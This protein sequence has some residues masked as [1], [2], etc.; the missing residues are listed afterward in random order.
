MNPTVVRFYTV[1][2]MGIA[3]Q[4]ISL[5]V[6]ADGLR[7]HPAVATFGAVQI[8]IAH[9]FVWHE[10]WTWAHRDVGYSAWQRYCR[11]VLSTGLISVVAN[12][13]VTGALVRFSAMPLTI[14]NLLAIATASVA[15]Y[16]ASDR[17]VFKY[18][19]HAP[20]RRPSVKFV[21]AGSV[22]EPDSER[23][24]AEFPAGNCPEHAK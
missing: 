15:N 16:L 17:F 10:R 5:I 23:S 2:L 19:G 13:L 7:L 1:G 4:L 20:V 12:L 24:N 21:R 14:A 3:V 8:A 9:N 11:F 18:R 22:S 6:L